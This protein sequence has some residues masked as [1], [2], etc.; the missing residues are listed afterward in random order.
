MP[1]FLELDTDIDGDEIALVNVDEI[2][3]ITHAGDTYAIVHL[4]CGT[5]VQ[6][7]E[8]VREIRDRLQKIGE[9]YIVS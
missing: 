1:V 4:R 3:G 2:T 7:N 9:T 8:S 5:Q 6:A